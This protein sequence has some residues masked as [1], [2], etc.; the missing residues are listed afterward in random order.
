MAFTHFVLLGL[1]PGAG[2]AVA[3]P[4]FT[5]GITE[6]WKHPVEESAWDSPPEHD[7][8]TDKEL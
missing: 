7:T 8:W 4:A 3:P 2:S 5:T 1:I 6:V